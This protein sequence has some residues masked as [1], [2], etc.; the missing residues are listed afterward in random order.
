VPLGRRAGRRS[1]AVDDRRGGAGPADRETVGDVEI[2]VVGE[3][4][5]QRRDLERVRARGDG[6]RVRAGVCVRLLDR[7][8]QSARS[9]ARATCAVADPGVA[10]VARVVDDEL[11]A[12]GA[13]QA[14]RFQADDE[15]GEKNYGDAGPSA[16]AGPR[17]QRL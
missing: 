10:E 9:G 8:A 16:S 3:V 17:R 12:G 13:R 7:G 14:C 11:E 15:G 1:A 4:L 5:I 2:A 6:D